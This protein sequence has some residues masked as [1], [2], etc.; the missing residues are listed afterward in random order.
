MYQQK[1]DIS[2]DYMD[3]EIVKMYL[4]RCELGLEDTNRTLSEFLID[5]YELQ[6]FQLEVDRDIIDSLQSLLMK[7]KRLES[8]SD[9]IKNEINNT[10]VGMF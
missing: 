2:D 10:V 4:K 9:E 8:T 7:I 6:R 1:L 5:K 3:V